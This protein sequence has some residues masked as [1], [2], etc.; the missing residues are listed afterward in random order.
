MAAT[1]ARRSASARQG[2]AAGRGLPG[3][4]GAER[5]QD[6][7]GHAVSR[8]LSR[9]RLHRLPRLVEPRAGPAGRLQ[10]RV[11]AAGRRQGVGRLHRLRRRLRRPL[12]GPGPRRAPSVGPGGRARRRALRERRQGGPHLA[13]HLRRRSRR[14]GHR[15]G[16]GAGRRRPLHR[17]TRCRRR[18]FT[19]TPESRRSFHR[20]PA[21]AQ[22]R[23]R[24]ARRSST[25]RS[26]GATCAGC[27]GADGI[28]TPVGPT[29][30][31]G[32]WLWGDGSLESI[33]ETIKNGV[34]EPKQH[35][36]AMPPM[37]G[38]ELSQAD[39]TPSPPTS[40][41]S[42]TR[43]RRSRRIPP[44][45]TRSNV[46]QGKSACPSRATTTRIP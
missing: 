18:A 24:S 14:Q 41:R 37:G 19:P 1:A 10:C 45:G 43:Q 7:Q 32:K 31:S 38:V 39:L 30:T 12:Q 11:P 26:A 29:F 3:A 15:G 13:H 42:A 27:H 33:T 36:G 44:R 28:G 34:P 22:S 21:H 35:P 17:P 5:S 2:R 20:R 40:G 46:H 9:R 23:S 6:L 4:L 8:R 25:A 16:A